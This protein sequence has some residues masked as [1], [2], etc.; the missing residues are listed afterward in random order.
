MNSKTPTAGTL[1]ARPLYQLLLVALERKLSGTLVLESKDGAKN[2]LTLVDGNVCKVKVASEVAKI[3]TVCIGAGLVTKGQL[4]K[5]LAASGPGLLGEALVQSGLI[6][7]QQLQRVLEDQVLQQMEWLAKLPPDTVF[8]FYPN[9]DYLQQWGG[10]ARTVDPLRVM[11]AC[12][13]ASEIARSFV[14]NTL[15]S[16]G[17]RPLRLHASSRVARFGFSKREQALVDVLRAKPQPAGTLLASGVVPAAEARRIL[18]ILILTRHID[19]GVSMLPLGVAPRQRPLTSERPRHRIQRASML[20]GA[21][22]TPA[23]P[24]ADETEARCQALRDEAEALLKSNY[25]DLLGVP[26]DA[27]VQVIQSAFLGKAKQWHPDK[28]DPTLSAVKPTVTKVF[29][30]MT[31]AHQVLTHGEQRAEY[32]KVLEGDGAADE[33]HEEIQ[34][35]LKAASTF[36][37]AEILV[38]RGE[39][40]QAK[41]AAKKASEGDPEQAEYEALYVWLLAREIKNGKKDDYVQLVNRL[42]K[43]VKQQPNN[44]AVR[45][46]RARVLK[47]AG[48]ENEAMR[49]FRSVVE[50]QPHHVEA[51]RELRLHRMRTG[52][53][54]SEEPGLF[55]RFFK[56]S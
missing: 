40:D 37:K 51:Q 30:K 33:E 54:E 10:D 6:D 19:L 48:M 46:Y 49:D 27:P 16:L 2:A 17:D 34:R 36:Q 13:R 31:E 25:Y 39:W 12:V 28:L 29:S 1:E 7:A 21:Q 15:A 4:E 38:K 45:L 22:K 9:K 23:E 14:D 43:A 35:V 32:D 5:V 55:G 8:G 20:S 11:W 47:L 53:G 41:E 52:P 42:V 56:K 3:G 26:S 18:I 50:A 24:S 44:T